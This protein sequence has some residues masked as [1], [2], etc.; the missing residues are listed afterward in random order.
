VY[1]NEDTGGQGIA[2]GHLSLSLASNELT[3]LIQ[4]HVAG[5]T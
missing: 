3:L 2:E 5:A 4:Q 1:V